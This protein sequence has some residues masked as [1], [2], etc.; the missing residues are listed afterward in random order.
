MTSRLW[1]WCAP[2]PAE[3]AA[4]FQARA[5]PHLEDEGVAEALLARAATGPEHLMVA[6]PE[7]LAAVVAAALGLP[8]EGAAALQV[9]EGRG[10]S[11]VMGPLGWELERFG[12]VGTGP[13]LAARL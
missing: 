9:D 4:A 5:V 1:L 10:A 6:G 3:A 2:L 13:H 7:R 8:P 12:I 11:L